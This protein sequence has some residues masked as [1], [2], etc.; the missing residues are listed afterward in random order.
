[1]KKVKFILVV[2]LFTNLLFSCTAEE[3]IDDNIVNTTEDVYG[4]GEDS[5]EEVDNER[6]G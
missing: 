2:I 5:D 3:T 4:T 6:D 1:M